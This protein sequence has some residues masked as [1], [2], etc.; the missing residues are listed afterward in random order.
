MPKDLPHFHDAGQFMLRMDNGCGVMG[1]VS[2]FMPDSMGYTLDL[3]WRIT[4]F[5]TQGIL[6]TTINSEAIMLAKNG[7]GEPE[8]V[9]P[10]EGDPG[11]YLRSFGEEIAAGRTEGVSTADVLR[12]AQVALIVQSAGY[13][14][15]FPIAL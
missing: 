12:A 9:P 2:Y 3:Y 11:G 8:M 15:R 1:E 7:A 5:G 6:E 4:L 13:S 14:G 10:A